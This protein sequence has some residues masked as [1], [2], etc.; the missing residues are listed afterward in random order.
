LLSAF[1]ELEQVTRDMTDKEFAK[2]LKVSQRKLSKWKTGLY[3]FSISEL[4][5]IFDKLDIQLNKLFNEI[6]HAESS[7]KNDK[8]T[9]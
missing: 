3:D 4:V 5:Y 9:N 6:Y 2:F 8:S 7:D 1:I